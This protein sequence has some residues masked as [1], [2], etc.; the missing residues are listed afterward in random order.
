M[1]I[2][3]VICWCPLTSL[4][5]LYYV[6]TDQVCSVSAVHPGRGYW[7]GVRRSWLT[8]TRRMKWRA[9]VAAMTGIQQNRKRYSNCNSYPRV[10]YRIFSIQLMFGQKLTFH[11][12]SI[13]QVGL[14]CW[15]NIIMLLQVQCSNVPKICEFTQNEWFQIVSLLR[16]HIGECYMPSLTVSYSIVSVD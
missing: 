7:P 16:I 13:I 6:F 14:P 10:L 8:T 5:Y 15:C 2:S 11:F 4:L 3:T 1:H 9:E 12:L